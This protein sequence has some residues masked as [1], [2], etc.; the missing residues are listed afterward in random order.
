MPEAGRCEVTELVNPLGCR[1]PVL[2]KFCNLLNKVFG[3]HKMRA[4]TQNMTKPIF[5]SMVRRIWK[6]GHRL[7]PSCNGPRLVFMKVTLSF[8]SLDSSPL[9]C[10]RSESKWHDQLHLFCF[11]P[12]VHAPL[13]DY[14]SKLRAKQMFPTTQKQTSFV[15]IMIYWLLKIDGDTLTIFLCIYS[16]TFCLEKDTPPLGFRPLHPR[17]ASSSRRTSAGDLRAK[18]AESIA[19][20]PRIVPKKQRRRIFVECKGSHKEK[21]L[22]PQACGLNV[23]W[24]KR[25]MYD[26]NGCSLRCQYG[27]IILQ[28]WGFSILEGDV[29]P[30]TVLAIKATVARLVCNQR[31]FCYLNVWISFIWWSCWK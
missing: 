9:R 19:S 2:W 20:W 31:L 30:P 27:F 12:L 28:S 25:I 3:L 22:I 11:W 5:D 4:T 7:A 8:G 24:N 6:W 14:S 26:M 18:A 17:K 29:T 23:Y 10:I 1:Q 21:H 15:Q 13:T 16:F